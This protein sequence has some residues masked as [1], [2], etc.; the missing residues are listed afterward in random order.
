MP[1]CSPYSSSTAEWSTEARD[2]GLAEYVAAHGGWL[3]HIKSNPIALFEPRSPVVPRSAALEIA[4]ALADTE[5]EVQFQLSL[6]A[7]LVRALGTGPAKL[8]LA[9][10][11]DI[12]LRSI[13]SR[14]HGKTFD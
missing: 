10:I 6:G 12:P 13:R 8:V 9:N 7:Q 5:V 2:R 14:A 3:G 4:C 1:I 11:L